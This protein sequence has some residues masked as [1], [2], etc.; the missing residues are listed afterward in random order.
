[1]SKI[2]PIFLIL[3]LYSSAISY[4]SLKKHALKNATVLQKQELN[5]AIITQQNNIIMR[6][7]NPTLNIEASHFNPEFANK[8]FGYG[9]TASQTIRTNG[10]YD[11]QEA[12]NSASVQL[13][14][15]YTQQTK[16]R[17]SRNFDRLYTQYVYESKRVTLFQ[18]EYQLASKITKMIHAQYQ[19]GSGT[20]VDYLQAKT[21]MLALKTQISTSK[22]VAN[23][24]LY[25]LLALAGFSKKVSLSKKFLYKTSI[26][27]PNKS[28]K[29][30]KEQILMA[31]NE[32]LKKKLALQ[33]HTFKQ[34]SLYGG[35]EKE[36]EQSILRFGVAVNLPIFNK[37]KEEQML[38][39]LQMMQLSLDKKQLTRTNAL[40]KE[41]LRYTLQAIKEQSLGLNRL[42]K[43]QKNL[44]R[45]LQEGY[46]IS[47]GSVFMMVNAQK[48]LIQT[49]KS[50][51]LTQ[52][53][54]NAK[55]IELHFLQ[56]AY[57]D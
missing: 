52:Q 32:L 41:Q 24:Y 55:T 38:T 8:E 48:R 17:Y 21:S 10:Y 37:N 3:T 53:L 20:K 29:T 42:K 54:F 18:D 7:Q 16:A 11:A 50:L 15:R 19:N 56:G 44:F 2:I 25:Q 57:N 35:I 51:L 5:L 22:Q 6:T 27:K 36:P 39:K 40:K 30:I 34:Y 4:Q 9:V 31:K 23:R 26:N 43:E 45:L 33:Q 12:Q 13:Q 1:M 46:N 28:K 49:Q 14:E 47:K